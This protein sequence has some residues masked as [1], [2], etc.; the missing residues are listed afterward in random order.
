MR[1][2]LI[3]KSKFLSLILRHDPSVVGVKLDESGWIDV[4][5]LL[6]AIQKQQ[7]NFSRACLDEIVA[8]ND[9]KRFV[10]SDDGSRIRASQGHSIRIN[11]GLP[12]SIPPDELFHGTAARNLPSIRDQGLIRGRRDHVHLSSD[13]DTARKVGMRHGRPVVLVIQAQQMSAAGHTFYLSDNGVWLT[14]AV[15]IEFICFP[16]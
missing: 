9:K 4:D 2:K 15:P 12:P 10:F 1:P 7:G 8:T 14:E 13:T 3:K 11:L 6:A 5:V 16:E